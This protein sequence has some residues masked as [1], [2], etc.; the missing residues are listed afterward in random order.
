M[1]SSARAWWYIWCHMKR[2]PFVIGA[3]LLAGGC[4]LFKPPPPPSFQAQIKVEG[5]PGQPIAGTEVL[6]KGK[7]IGITDQSG[8]LE[9]KLKGSEGQVFD[10]VVKCPQGYESPSKPL[11]VTLRRLAEPQATPEY[12]VVCAPSLRT[13]VVAVRAENGPNIPVVY[14]GRERTRTDQSGAAHL[15]L[16]VPP[17]QPLQLKLDTTNAKDLRPESPTQT[18]QVKNSDDVLVLEQ[19]FEVERKRVIRYGKKKSTGPKPL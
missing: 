14:L 12:R 9:F 16:K 6:Y 17:N 18:V 1:G 8:M 19:T 5:D 13:I 11:S 10:L 4:S 15:V 7:Q 2:L 3:V